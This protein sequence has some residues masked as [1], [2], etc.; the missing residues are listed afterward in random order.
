LVAGIEHH[1]VLQLKLFTME[2]HTYPGW[3]GMHDFNKLGLTGMIIAG[4]MGHD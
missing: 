2:M 3:L 1:I 4:F